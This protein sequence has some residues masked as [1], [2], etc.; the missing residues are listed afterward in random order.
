MD[1]KTI[2]EQ[3]LHGWK[4]SVAHSVARRADRSRIP[5][6]ETQVRG[7]LGVAFFTMSLLYVVKTLRAVAR[8]AG[9]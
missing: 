5:V 9:D 6:T 8:E 4:G 2:G 7:V 3:G 1:V